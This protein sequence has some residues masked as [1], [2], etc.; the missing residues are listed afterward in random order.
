MSLS[1]LTR[2]H[3]SLRIEGRGQEVKWH[4]T[5]TRFGILLHLTCL[6]LEH[7]SKDQMPCILIRTKFRALICIMCI[8]DQTNALNSTVVFLL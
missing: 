6:K 7:W 5:S 2:T 8:K 4:F 3:V 1:S